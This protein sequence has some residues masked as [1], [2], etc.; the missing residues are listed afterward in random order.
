MHL[1]RING[2]GNEEIIISDTT[3]AASLLNYIDGNTTGKLM[4]LPLLHLQE[5]FLILIALMHL[6]ESMV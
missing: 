3:I 5:I 1:L 2:L 4:F 6:L